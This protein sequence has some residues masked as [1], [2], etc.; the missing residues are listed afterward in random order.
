MRVAGEI[1]IKAAGNEMTHLVSII[2]RLADEQRHCATLS[3]ESD[4]SRCSAAAA[5]AFCVCVCVREPPQ[6]ES[7]RIIRSLYLQTQRRGNNTKK[8]GG[9][10]EEESR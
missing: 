9:G 10:E 5:A 8:A 7:R 3:G 6:V 2:H 4:M 1:M